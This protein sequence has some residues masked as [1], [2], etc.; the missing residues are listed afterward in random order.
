[1]GMSKINENGRVTIP[2]AGRAATGLVVG[3]RR[4]GVPLLDAI[5]RQRATWV[6]SFDTDL[7]RLGSGTAVNSR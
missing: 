6:L 3:D 1:M 4:R 7:E 5:A 2:K